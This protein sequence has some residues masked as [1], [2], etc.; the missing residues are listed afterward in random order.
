MRP[1]KGDKGECMRDRAISSRWARLGF[2]IASS[3]VVPFASA[4]ADQLSTQQEQARQ[5]QLRLLC[6]TMFGG[7]FTNPLGNLIFRRC[8]QDPES[9]IR[10][11]RPLYLPLHPVP[12]VGPSTPLITGSGGK[13]LGSAERQ[14]P[15]SDHTPTPRPLVPL[16]AGVNKGN[17]VSSDGT[18][19]YFFWAGPGH[20]RVELAFKEMGIYGA[21]MRQA[22]S[23]DLLGDRAQI[24]DHKSITS[25]SGLER[26]EISENFERRQKLVL[27][28]KAQTSLIQMGGYYEIAVIGAADFDKSAPDTSKVVP[29]DTR[30]VNP[31]APLITH[32][33][34]LVGSSS[35]LVR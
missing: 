33:Q 34:S 6:A 16:A 8:L 10:Q 27:A 7:D 30:L 22:L 12:L 31:G 19:S 14:G 18:R 2:A 26:S 5:A 23:F 29:K 4:L 20:I 15:V 21:P 17:I 11:R 13:G 1:T 25:E 9:M 24:L 28:I 35:G 32:S 3:L